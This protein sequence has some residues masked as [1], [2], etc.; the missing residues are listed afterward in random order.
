[1]WPASARTATTSENT[2]SNTG[3]MRS[4]RKRLTVLWSRGR[5]PVSHMRFTFSRV[6]AAILRLE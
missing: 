5:M 3:R 6:A 1:M 4:E 2:S